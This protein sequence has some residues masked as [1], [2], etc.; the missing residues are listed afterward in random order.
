MEIAPLKSFLVIAEE[1]HMTRAAQRLHLTQPAV[2]AQLKKL[3]DEL[4]QSLFHRT[5]KGL[6]LT[7]AGTLFRSYVEDALMRLSDGAEALARLAG[8]EQGTLS[9][10]GGATATTYLLPALLGRFHG[11][12]PAIRI[13]V[14]EQGSQ[15]VIEAVL[16]GQL[17]LGVV[18]LPVD[19]PGPRLAVTP[20]M[21]DELRLIVPPGHRLE[22]RAS[23]RWKDLAGSP[24]VLFEAQ[25]SVRNLI[26][27]RLAEAKT[28]VEIVMEL[29][30]IES[31][32]EMVA[33]GIGAAFVSRYAL[34][35]SESGLRCAD[36]PL[37]RR[38]GI[39]HRAD[40]ALSA[41]AS[42]FLEEMQALE[43]GADRRA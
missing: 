34:R 11:R 24:L 15:S 1:G 38:L 35:G 17:D 16:A 7:Q 41:A 2:S 10:G 39:V 12:H 22:G 25:T 4:G 23:F 6:V 32:K 37:A 5:P 9:I 40:R 26:D 36:G 21:E 18:T 8:L 31:I 43:N 3:E 19:E 28:P 42:A 30:S 27:G 33:Q 29:R 14:R 20:W 13:F